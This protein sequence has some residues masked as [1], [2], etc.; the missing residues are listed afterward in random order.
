MATTITADKL[1]KKLKTLTQ[2]ISCF[3]SSSLEYRQYLTQIIRLIQQSR[4]LRYE[5]VD[6]YEDALCLTLQYLCQQLQPNTIWT[7]GINEQS[8]IIG[9]LNQ[10]LKQKLNDYREREKIAE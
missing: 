4:C 1:D 7:S 6:Y 10:Y 3:S 5:Q 2:E 9:W 8:S